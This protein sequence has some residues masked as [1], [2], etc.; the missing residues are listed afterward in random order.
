MDQEKIG[1]ICPAV[2]LQDEGAY[3]FPLRF[4]RFF[5][6]KLTAT[7]DEADFTIT[8]GSMIKMS[9]FRDVGYMDE[10]LFIDYI[11]Y[12]FCLRLRDEGYK[13]LYVKDAVLNHELGER[14]ISNTGIQHTSHAAERIYYQTRNRLVVVT[15]HGVKFPAFALM[16]LSLFVLKFFKILILEDQKLTRLRHYFT[17]IQIGR[18]HV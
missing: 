16:Q 3:Q 13:I 6:K 9:L 2:A 8:S 11:D 17:G 1:L 12:D 4:G 14:R 15:R 18:A 7:S 10:Q 5:T